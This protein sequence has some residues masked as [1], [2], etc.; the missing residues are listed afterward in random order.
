M[1][2]LRPIPVSLSKNSIIYLIVTWFHSGRVRPASGTWGTLAALPACIL[3]SLL[4]G[5]GG[6]FVFVIITACAGVWAIER[7]APHADRPDPSEVVIDEV[8]GMAITAIFIPNT[9]SA[10][11]LA[12]VLFRLFDSIKR[13]PVGWCDKHFK[14][15]VGVMADDAVAGIFAGV[16]TFILLSLVS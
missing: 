12:F 14:G 13:G 2:K 6:L 5:P 9:I 16:L 10:W 8:M 3:I 1:L 4:S 15:A 11:I 7:Y